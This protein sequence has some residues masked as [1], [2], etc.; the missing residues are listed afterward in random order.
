MTISAPVSLGNPITLTNNNG[1]LLSLS[2]GLNANSNLLTFSGTQATT[3]SGAGFTN[4]V[5]ATVN[6]GAGVVTISAPVTLSSSATFTNNSANTLQLAAINTADNPLTITGNGNTAISGAITD[7]TGLGSLSQNGSGTLTLSGSSNYGGGTTLALGVLDVQ[8]SFALGTGSLSTLCNSGISAILRLDSPTGIIIANN[9]LTTGNG[10]GGNESTGGDVGTTL[11]PGVIQNVQGNNVLSGV[12]TLTNGGGQSVYKSVSGSLTISG[13]VTTFPYN[14]P[15]SP[16]VRFMYLGGTAPGYIPGVLSELGIATEVPPGSAVGDYTLGVTKVDSDM[17]T[18]SGTANNWT[19][20]LTVGNGTLAIAGLDDQTYSEGING[21]G[22]ITIGS[23]AS[24]TAN[25]ATL[26]FIGSGSQIVRTRPIVLGGSARIDASGAAGSSIAF[27]STAPISG[28]Y[29]LTLTGSGTGSLGESI[30]TGTGS[31]TKNGTGLWTLYGANTYSGGTR[32]NGGTLQTDNNSSNTVLG[33]GGLTV[34]GGM[35][36]LIGTGQSVTTLSGS[37]GGVIT[38]S[39]SGGTLTVTGSGSGVF[40][41]SIQDGTDSMADDFPVSLVL[42][43]GE[44]AL[45]GTNTY[46]GGTLVSGG[47]L[48]LADNQ[49]LA[50]G[51]S[52][53]VGDPTELPSSVFAARGAAELVPEPGTL[54]LLGVGAI[55]VLL[56]RLGRRKATIAS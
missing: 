53:T 44:L 18:I 11:G 30:A 48:M 29:N 1:S 51:S 40:A 39:V 54:A 37:A 10:T 5:G 36:D 42:S 22:A 25:P 12:I 9:I 50:G 46:S 27:D 47:T 43:G 38:S 56:Y 13:T 49:A 28:N 26:Q 32:V 55:F 7:L 4:S 8:N 52:L 17:W 15:A 45:T 41:G 35:V 33:L 24:T 16:A 19:A 6:G 21:T 23:S 20:A 14:N 31:L 3:I 34:N 2:G